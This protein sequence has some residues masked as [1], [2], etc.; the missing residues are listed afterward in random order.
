LCIKS[1]LYWLEVIDN[2][3]VTF[4]LSSAGALFDTDLAVSFAREVEAISPMSFGD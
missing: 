3:Y 2:M 4:T 1:N